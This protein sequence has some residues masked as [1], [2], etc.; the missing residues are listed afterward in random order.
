LFGYRAEFSLTLKTEWPEFIVQGDPRV[1]QNRYGQIVRVYV[2]FTH[3]ELNLFK[4]ISGTDEFTLQKKL[5]QLMVSWDKKYRSYLDKQ[6]AESGKVSAE[7]VV[8]DAQTRIV[9]L[10]NILR[11]TLDV[12]DSVD[13]ESLKVQ[14]S[15]QPTPF[16]KSKPEA[17]KRPPKPKLVIPK[18]IAPEYRIPTFNAPQITVVQRLLGQARRRQQQA[19]ALWESNNNE[20]KARHSQEVLRLQAEHQARVETLK[21]SHQAELEEYQNEREKSLAAH[22]C[23]VKKWQDEKNM[24]EE[25]QK[26]LEAQE[27]DRA[28]AHNLQMDALKEQWLRGESQAVVEH[29]CLVLDASIY[30]EWFQGSYRF[31]YEP[32]NKLGM[33]EFLLPAP[34]VVE[35][36]KS[37]RFVATTGEITTSNISKAQQKQLYDDL[38]YQV[39]LRTVHELFEADTPENLSSI[40]FNGVVDQINPATGKEER[41]TIMSGMFERKAFL[42]AD[43]ARVEPKACFK[44]FKGVS[45]ASLIGLAPVAPI[46][47]ITRDDQRFIEGRDLASEVDATVNLAAMDWEDFEHLVREI[48]GREFEL[49]GGEV[50]VTQ[51]SSDGG[52]DAVAFDPDPIS[53]G[54]IVIQAKRYTRTV[55]VAAVRDLYGTVMNEGAGKGILVTTADYGPDAY[56]FAA[57]KPL[58]LLNGAN[59]LFMLEKHG[60]NAKIDIPAARKALGLGT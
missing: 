38:C 55:G 16:E 13:W 5:D 32:S 35:L 52:V 24:W 4:E 20:A 2:P 56:K 22:Q 30:P 8:D 6:S 39:A 36:P 17:P 42:E 37:A 25:E 29:A 43:L 18:F 48:F 60:V 45:A 50:K 33:V 54:K 57:D 31:N 53:G 58:T 28:L 11:A 49:R 46:M 14:P 51:S 59:L 23:R 26:R 10:S 21:A 12:D 34:K 44:S 7:A 1:T 3:S 47:E 41:L 9:E 40:L 19:R 27:Q 15:L